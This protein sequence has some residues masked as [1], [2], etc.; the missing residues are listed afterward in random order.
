MLFADAIAA[1][2]ADPAVLLEVMCPGGMVVT[3]NLTPERLWT[4]SSQ[5]SSSEMIR[6]GGFGLVITG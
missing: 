6:Y 1:K 2:K 4:A 3:D 5:P